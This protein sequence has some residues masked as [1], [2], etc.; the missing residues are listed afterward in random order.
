MCVLVVTAMVAL[1]HQVN[2]HL[3]TKKKR[4]FM[5]GDERLPEQAWASKAAA[6]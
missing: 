4:P 1:Q 5:Y 6:L 2:G 3:P